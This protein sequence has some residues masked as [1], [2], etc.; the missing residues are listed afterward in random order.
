MTGRK[1]IKEEKTWRMSQLHSFIQLVEKGE[2]RDQGGKV[3]RGLPI[4]SSFENM[5]LLK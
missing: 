5:E 1:D 2:R 4:P 3:E